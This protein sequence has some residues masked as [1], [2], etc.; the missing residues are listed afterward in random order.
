MATTTNYS[1]ELPTVSGDDD[2][3]GTKLNSNWSDL[4][5]L[6]S[7]TGSV[8]GVVIINGNI[9][10][11]SFAL[12]G[13]GTITDATITADQLTV[14]GTALFNEEIAEKKHTV[15]GTSPTLDP[16]NGPR[17]KW[18]L[19]ANSSF[20]TS[21]ADGESMTLIVSTAGFDLTFPTME[22]LGGV[23]PTLDASNP[24]WI[25]LTNESGTIVGSYAGAQ[26]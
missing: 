16:G 22:W 11:T 8:D 2:A 25:V 1:F 23:E 19:T 12:S 26:S 20:S 3:W 5:D 15:T 13:S 24:N 10:A 6:L 18:T 21:L 14:D 4:D 9:T 7:G 17:Q